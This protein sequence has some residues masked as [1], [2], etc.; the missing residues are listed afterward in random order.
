MVHL[1]N[2]TAM[3]KMVNLLGVTFSLLFCRI[4]RIPTRTGKPGKIGRHFPV[5]EY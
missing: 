3:L 4:T 1:L 2:D 5:R